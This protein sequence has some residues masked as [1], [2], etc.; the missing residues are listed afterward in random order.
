MVTAVVLCLGLNLPLYALDGRFAGVHY[1]SRSQAVFL[2]ALF[3]G[4]GQLTTG[5]RYRGT[6]LMASEMACLVICLTSHEDYKTQLDQFNHEKDYYLSLRRGRSF[7]E[8]EESWRR[9]E[10]L[11]DNV[12]GSHMRRC[13]FGALAAT[14]YIYN[15][16]D[17]SLLGGCEPPSL[18]LVPTAG[19]GGL[20]V[21]LSSRF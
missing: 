2:S 16:L 13:L 17:A 12:D 20:M 7:R 8:A 6:A 4:L 10:K 15:L 11:K 1:A 9:L 21:V 19:H 18:G 14:V 3:P 5:H